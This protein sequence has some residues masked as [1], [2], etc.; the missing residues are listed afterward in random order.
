MAC[1][2][3]LFASCQGDVARADGV[4]GEWRV[5]DVYCSTCD[6]VKRDDLGRVLRISAAE[7]I[8]PFAGGRCPGK[9][10]QREM[11]PSPVQQKEMLRK[12]N[13]RWFKTVPPPGT[14]RVIAVTCDDLDFTTLV[15]LSQD[16]LGYVAEGDIT[17][18]LERVH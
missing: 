10:G 7:I 1:S 5:D 8:D 4:I 16:H 17:Y 9:V 11:R 12:L 2:W 18:R 15:I 14:L 3:A 13:P 6:S